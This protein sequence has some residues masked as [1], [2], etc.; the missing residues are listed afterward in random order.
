[1]GSVLIGFGYSGSIASLI[2]WNV[3]QAD[4]E[5]RTASLAVQESFS[6]LGMAAGSLLFGLIIQFIGMSLSYSVAGVVL[7]IYAI[8]K[9]FKVSRREDSDH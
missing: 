4:V 3:D 9:L 5:L 1:M 7:V 8:W 6:D 2:A